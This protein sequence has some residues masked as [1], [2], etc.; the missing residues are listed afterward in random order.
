MED[1]LGVPGVRLPFIAVVSASGYPVEDTYFLYFPAA[2]TEP[3]S[4]L[5]LD[6]LLELLL[7]EVQD[8]VR[9]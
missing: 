2:A 7:E 9:T 3:A 8:V 1:E 6:M 4:D 5:Q